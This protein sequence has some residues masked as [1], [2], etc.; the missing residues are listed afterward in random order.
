M[1]TKTSKTTFLKFFLGGFALGLGFLT[2]SLFA[3]AVGTI[4]T[5]TTGETLT[6]TDLNTTINSLKTAIEGIPNWTKKNTVDAYLSGGAIVIDQ[7]Y[8]LRNNL[9]RWL[10]G[11]DS[12]TNLIHIGDVNTANDIRFDSITG[13]LLQIKSTGNVGIGTAS[14]SAKMDVVA[15]SSPIGLQVKSKSTDLNTAA[16][17]LINSNSQ[18]LFGVISDG[19]F[20]FSNGTTE[21]VRITPTG[22]VG[23]GNTS[24]AAKLHVSDTSGTGQTILRLQ[25]ASTTCNFTTANG[26]PTCGSDVRYK[27]DIEAVDSTSSLHGILNINPIHYHWKKETG[28]SKKHL[29]FT[30]QNIESQFPELVEPVNEAGMKGLNMTLLIPHLVN[31]V[32]ELKKEK[33]S[34]SKENQALKERLE[35]LENRF[36]ALERVRK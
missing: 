17:L 26:A 19:R 31:S 29:G 32:K 36:T 10:L 23:I 33:D 35:K 18:D 8:A 13:N 7:D 6:H 24:P 14:P 5:W 15:G 16:L 3:V 20:S 1:D 9:G 4:K 21:N 22:S 27:K 28:Q 12:G 30:A 11:Q 25:D 2:A 34:L